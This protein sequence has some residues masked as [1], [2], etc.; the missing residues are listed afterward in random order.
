MFP[1]ELNVLNMLS[2]Y[3]RSN[4]IDY[5]YHF[6]RPFPCLALHSNSYSGPLN[7]MNT[8]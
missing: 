8:H 2:L 4:R 6:N 3:N 7:K 1:N 5:N